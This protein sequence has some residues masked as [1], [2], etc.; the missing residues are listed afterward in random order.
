MF[1]VFNGHRWTPIVLET[2]AAVRSAPFKNHKIAGPPRSWLFHQFV[3]D[4]WGSG[5]ACQENGRPV[6]IIM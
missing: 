5:P 1:T 4:L 2:H 6:F 3:F